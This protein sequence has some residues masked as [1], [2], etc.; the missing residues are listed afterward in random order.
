MM[1]RI[2][3]TARRPMTRREQA[4]WVKDHVCKTCRLDPSEVSV[5]WAWGW[6]NARLTVRVGRGD[7]E[8]VR[9]AVDDLL[10]HNA[11][12]HDVGVA[13]GEYGH[14]AWAVQVRRDGK[15]P[16]PRPA[17]PSVTYDMETL[18]RIDGGG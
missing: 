6:G 16:R 2:A 3:R 9:T 8:A 4:Q 14:P 7:P 11:D 10:T 17:E 1:E 5:E 15:P 18:R 12:R 13:D